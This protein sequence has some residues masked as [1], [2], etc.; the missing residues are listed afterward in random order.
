MIAL[1]RL[2]ARVSDE[3]G[4]LYLIEMMFAAL[5]EKVPDLLSQ[6]SAQNKAIHNG[7][8]D[9]FTASSGT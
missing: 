3:H 1:D 4:N 7:S 2:S 8:A 5:Q 6:N 9:L